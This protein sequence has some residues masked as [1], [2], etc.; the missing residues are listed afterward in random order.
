MLTPR[1]RLMPFNGVESSGWRGRLAGGYPPVPR[2]RRRGTGN[3]NREGNHLERITNNFSGSRFVPVFQISL[4]RVF[5][6]SCFRDSISLLK[7]TNHCHVPVANATAKNSPRA[8][9]T[10]AISRLVERS[11]TTGEHAILRFASWKDARYSSKGRQSRSPRPTPIL[12][13]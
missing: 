13:L 9:G 6:L 4:F 5:E 10:S 7:E 8:G 1:S 3:G 2:S 12:I 11:D